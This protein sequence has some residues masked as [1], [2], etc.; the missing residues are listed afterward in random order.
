MRTTPTSEAPARGIQNLFG[1]AG[2]K[3]TWAL[4]LATT[5]VALAAWFWT[6]SLI[7]ARALPA[8]GIGDWTHSVTAPINL[9]F[10]THATAANALLIVSSGLIDLM[11]VFLLGS[12]LLQ[13]ESQPFLGLVIVLALRQVMQACM[14][15]PAPPNQIWH[16]PGFPSLLVT[17]GVANDYFFSGHTAIAVLA[18]TELIRYG[19][20]WLTVL[21]V[22]LV[23]FEVAVV[24]VLRAHY[25]MDVFTGLITGLY[26]AH[27]ADRL[28]NH[29]SL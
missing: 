6:Q 2:S 22:T 17:Y 21:A 28:T 7:G 9:Y 24:L 12:W 15:L 19:R 29:A 11:G 8:S 25:V 5:A 20:K 18:G 26:A 27:L 3:W 10:L 14:A 4:R 1:K 23:I 16:N 13:G